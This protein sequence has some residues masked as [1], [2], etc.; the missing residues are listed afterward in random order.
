MKILSITAQKP[1]STGSGVYLSELVKGF[2][3]QGHQQAVIAGVYEDDDIAF[4]GDVAFYPVFFNTQSL[5]FPIAGMSD[6]MPYESTVY[7]QMTEEMI[8]QFKT[9]FG[10]RI[11]E[12]VREFSPDLILCHHLYFQATKYMAFVIIQICG[13]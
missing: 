2:A 8:V 7:A 12:A 10:K 1:D 13:R 4:P 6:E 9:A 3:V 11:K 5:P